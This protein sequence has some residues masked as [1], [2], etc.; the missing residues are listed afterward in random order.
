MAAGKHVR[1]SAC[2][3]AALLRNGQP[4]SPPLCSLCN[5]A[6]AWPRAW[7]SCRQRS[8]PATSVTALQAGC[9]A[10]TDGLSALVGTAT[11]SGPGGQWL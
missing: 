1:V 10:A 8:S 3:D 2:S 5:S 9:M 6:D 7:L 11:R 4:Q